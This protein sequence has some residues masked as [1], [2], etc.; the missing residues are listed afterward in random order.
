MEHIRQKPKET[1]IRSKGDSKFTNLSGHEIPGQA[2]D[3]VKA[4]RND[5]E[6]EGW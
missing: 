5:E 2:R 4:V 3:D 1:E 6:D